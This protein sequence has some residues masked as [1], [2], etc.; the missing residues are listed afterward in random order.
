MK[1]GDY[2]IVDRRGQ[3]FRDWTESIPFCI[4]AFT[5]SL[6]HAA[7]WHDLT[8]ARAIREKIADRLYD[9]EGQRLQPRSALAIAQIGMKTI[10]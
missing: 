9:F 4:H 7:R 8:D 10:E 5:D 3:F 6:D 2:V 1:I